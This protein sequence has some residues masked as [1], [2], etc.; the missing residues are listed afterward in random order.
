MNSMISRRR[1]MAL[2]SGTATG[3]V[4]ATAATSAASAPTQADRDE[5][6]RSLEGRRALIGTW[7]LTVKFEDGLENPTLISFDKAGALVETNALTRSTGLGTW[8]HI[9]SAR[10]HYVFWEQIFDE[11]SN[12]QS[13][14]RVSHD[15]KVS[16]SGNSYHGDGTGEIFD[17]DWQPTITVT[18]KITARRLI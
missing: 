10:Y 11:N 14:V 9:S 15:L 12:L 7:A 4:L 6:R 16:K 2:V 1:S 3:V 8:K 5:S 17:L 13:H 18:T